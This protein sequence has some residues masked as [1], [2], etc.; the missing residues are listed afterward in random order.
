MLADHFERG[1]VPERAAVWYS[2]AT[3]A[4]FEA[5]ALPEVVRCGDQAVR[6][7]VDGER[8]GEV[9]A[10]VA[11]ALS[12]AGQHTDAI[13]WAARARLH[14]TPGGA[15]W[16]R[17]SQALVTSQLERG[18]REQAAQPI[19]D[20]LA[21]V[22][23][24][25]LSPQVLVT[26]AISASNALNCQLGD[27]GQRLL[28]LLETLSSTGLPAR[29]RGFLHMAKAYAVLA[30]GAEWS[31][32][33][34][35]EA[36]VQFQSAGSLK[37][38]LR[39]QGNLGE[40]LL[41]AGLLEEAEARLREGMALADKLGSLRDTAAC[42]QQLALTYLARGQADLADQTL[43]ASLRSVERLQSSR[44]QI[45]ILARL[46]QA[47]AARGRLDEASEL[48]RQARERSEVDPT[49][50]ALVLAVSAE[51]DRQQGMFESSLTFARAAMALHQAHHLAEHVALI[52]SAL[53]EALLGCGQ[54][55]EARASLGDA[56]VWLHA[57]AD[58]FEDPA[59]R[60]SFLTRVP[61]NARLMA[62]G[63]RLALACT[64]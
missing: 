43:R 44:E 15:T 64:G 10:L 34:T 31:I 18:L 56:L 61:H 54:V 58:S 35:R 27:C 21:R 13:E 22:P 38:V 16:W 59:W 1:D 49:T 7:G 5:D 30:S 28:G 57:R 40:L 6:C 37:D 26:L 24:G 19:E 4:A 2:A 63:E 25:A 36:V 11:E 8:L 60:C 62:L 17:A 23:D 12:Y 53:V 42:G 48:I 55:D 45:W 47:V 52:W 41:S 46:A 9:A 50:R 39:T 51:V 20:M 32:Q 14:A 33:E 29:P 3:E